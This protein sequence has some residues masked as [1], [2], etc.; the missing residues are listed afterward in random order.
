MIAKTAAANPQEALTICE[1]LYAMPDLLNSK[2][3]NKYFDQ[4]RATI[5]KALI[6]VNATLTLPFTIEA[7]SEYALDESVIQK[8]NNKTLLTL[9][10]IS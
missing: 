3:P 2:I 7:A 4:F 9:G 1:R 8:A 10:G 5:P 6:E